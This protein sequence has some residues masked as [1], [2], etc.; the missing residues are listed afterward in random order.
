M[1][2]FYAL[3]VLLIIMLMRIHQTKD[4]LFW[5]YL[6]DRVVADN[7]ILFLSS[8]QSLLVC[9]AKCS[10]YPGC[11]SIFYSKSLCQGC[12]TI[13]YSPLSPE[14]MPMPGTRYY[15][16]DEYTNC[17]SQQ[18]LQDSANGN[19]FSFEKYMFVF[20]QSDWIKINTFLPKENKSF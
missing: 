14:L 17:T 8:E 2:R 10:M 4:V 18:N 16:L 6:C 15:I 13:V 12:S 19:F 5:E 20:K 7:S 11:T 1:M 9:V 3:K